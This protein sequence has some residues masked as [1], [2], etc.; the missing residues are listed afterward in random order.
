MRSPSEVLDAPTQ[1]TSTREAALEYAGR[2][3]SVLPTRKKRPLTRRG[4][5]DATTDASVIERWFTAWPDAGVAIA[6]GNGVMALDV[7]PRHG[8]HGTL[9]MLQEEH[10][11]LPVTA[12]VATGGGGVHYYFA[13]DGPGWT[14]GPGLE[15]KGR[16][17][18]VVAPPSLHSSGT[19]Y[20]WERDEPLA[21]LPAWTYSVRQAPKVE[22]N[23]ER[24]EK[25]RRN[26]TLFSL[27]CGI[28]HRTPSEGALLAWARAI[29]QDF[30]AP[31]LS[32]RDVAKLVRSATTKYPALPLWMADP[33]GFV[34]RA[35]VSPPTKLVLQV[36]CE[37]SNPEGRSHPGLRRLRQRT[38][39]SHRQV[40]GAVDELETKGHI[41][42]TRG[43]R[44]FSNR[45]QLLL[46]SLNNNT[47][48]CSGPLSCLT[49]ITSGEAP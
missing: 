27:V 38:G 3:W 7:D 31:P 47:R 28:R 23:G 19:R 9:A 44:T 20:A 25:G 32:D 42:V 40:R 16:G 43:N 12:T 37:H 22:W 5:N 49:R 18:Y 33:L 17:Q 10:G 46:P 30:C 6:T 15:I 48:W 39:L 29:N 13:G 24:I 34:A 35:D 45:Y 36:L 21:E 26:T 41:S 1:T 4:V 8:G 2:G 11:E 14:I